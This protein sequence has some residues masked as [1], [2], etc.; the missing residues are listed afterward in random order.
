[1]D[2]YRHQ[3]NTH[4]HILRSFSYFSFSRR[5]IYRLSVWAPSSHSHQST[6]H[7]YKY[8]LLGGKY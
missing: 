2:G 8:L 1:M 4:P 5:T 3:V 6:D 7:R